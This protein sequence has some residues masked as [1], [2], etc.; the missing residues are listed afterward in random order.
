M[1]GSDGM[2]Y[3]LAGGSGESTSNRPEIIKIDPDTGDRSLVW[4]AKNTKFSPKANEKYGQCYR[5]NGKYPEKS[6]VGIMALAFAMGPK[7]EF[8][9]SMHD[10]R[11]GEGI[12]KIS[13]DAKTLYTYLCLG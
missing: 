6:S 11:A 12:L 7:D 3:L 5:P 8:Y 2:I 1:G 9:L 4:K 13:P 10:I